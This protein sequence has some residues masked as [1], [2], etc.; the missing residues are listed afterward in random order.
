MLR[1][2]RP[3]ERDAAQTC[4][5]V[6]RRCGRYAGRV[7]THAGKARNGAFARHPRVHARGR[8]LAGALHRPGSAAADAPGRADQPLPDQHEH[9]RPLHQRADRAPRPGHGPDDH[10]Q[11]LR[12][13]VRRLQA[14]DDSEGA[15]QPDATPADAAAADATRQVSGSP[16]SV[17][18]IGTGAM[19]MGVVRS[20]V[21]HGVRT[22]TR[23]IR[24]AADREAALLGAMP[25]A[26]PAA[27]ATQVDIVIVL[28]VDDAQ[29][30]DVLFGPG[31]AAPALAR[32][33]V[34]VL[35]ST[36]DPAFVAGLAPRLREMNVQLVDAPVSGGPARASEGTMM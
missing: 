6:D 1:A 11:Q 5:R 16:R 4:L 18:V 12:T 17:G 31:G 36:L 34:V 3:G 25:C 8:A 28:V 21:R 29:V 19:G 2:S 24:P 30:D 23:D 26:S 14:V 22:F 20:L 32:E 10:P 13:R 35:S 15:L 27:L 7:C 33:S 9:R